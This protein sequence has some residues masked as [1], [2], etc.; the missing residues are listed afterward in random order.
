[1]AQDGQAR[2]GLVEVRR[3]DPAEKW[4]VRQALSVES[5]LAGFDSPMVFPVFGRGHVMEPYLGKGITTANLAEVAAFMRGPCACEVK[6]SSAGVDLLTDQDWVAALSGW[7]AAPAARSSLLLGGLAGGEQPA[8]AKPAK[9]QPPAERQ[10]AKP[11]ARAGSAPKG[12]ATTAAVAAAGIE[13]QGGGSPP[14]ADGGGPGPK[15]AATTAQ[16]SGARPGGT[17]PSQ[18]RQA[19][20]GPA[21]QQATV[22]AAAVV[23]DQAGGSLGGALAWRL[24]LALGAAAVMVA[25]GGVL[26]IRRQTGRDGSREPV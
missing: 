19:T 23:D 11:A 21:L 15:P 2:F 26:L 25:L 16:P 5:D 10:A 17:A 18:E 7:A 3:D 14:S 12:D 8:A 9:P 22:P 13:G 1:M 20:S 4:L 6:D 24:G